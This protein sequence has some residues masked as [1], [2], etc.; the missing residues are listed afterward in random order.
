MFY[1]FMSHHSSSKIQ[2]NFNIIFMRLDARI[3][4]SRATFSRHPVTYKSE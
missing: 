4:Y 2:Y 3:F 1:V